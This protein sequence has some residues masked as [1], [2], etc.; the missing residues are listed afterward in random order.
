MNP[1][2]VL[3]VIISIIWIIVGTFLIVFTAQTRDILQKYFRI[4]NMK[5]PAVAAF[6]LGLALI[7]GGLFKR[8]ILVLSLILGLL[9]IGKGI[10]IFFGSE[11]QIENILDWWYVRARDETLRFWGLIT[12]ILG[13]AVLWYIL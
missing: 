13:F 2:F 6:I 5:V 12:F 1:A 11:R 10:F 4:E 7:V 9:G 3:L 8:D